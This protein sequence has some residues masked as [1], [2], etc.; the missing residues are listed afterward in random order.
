MAIEPIISYYKSGLIYREEWYINGK[1]HRVNGPAY[2]SYYESG[3]IHKEKWYL[4]GKLHRVN[5]PAYIWCNKSGIIQEEKWY[6]NGKETTHKEWLI[7]P[8]INY[9][10]SGKIYQKYWMINSNFHRV[11]GPAY[12]SY[13]ESGTIQEEKWYLNGKFHRVDGPADSYY[14]KSGKI[15]REYW[16]LNGN[17]SN[18][19]E[20]LLEHNLYNK[21]YNTWA[22]EGKVLWRLTWI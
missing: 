22:D 15:E 19:K 2:I 20:W 16:Y 4:N 6:L 5:G 17:V 13:Y 3:T 10:D 14:N 9:Y 18:H 21:P 1:F 12:I 8:T 7:E 11:D